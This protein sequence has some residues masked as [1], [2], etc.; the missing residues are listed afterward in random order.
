MLFC[1]ERQQGAIADIHRCCCLR[2]VVPALQDYKG[3]GTTLEIARHGKLVKDCNELRALVPDVPGNYVWAIKAPKSRLWVPV[4]CGKA[5][6]GKS[7]ATLRRRFKAFIWRKT[8]GPLAEPKKRWAM[9]DAMSRGFSIQCRSV[10]SARRVSVILVV[11]YLH[12]RP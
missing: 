2:A 12:L 7:R 9:V 10:P 5:G 3:R 1:V 8:F 11:T 6:G 4:Y